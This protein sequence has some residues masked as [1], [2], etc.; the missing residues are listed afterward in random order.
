MTSSLPRVPV[1]DVSTDVRRETA[2]GARMAAEELVSL[3]HRRIAAI[4]GPAHTSTG[5]DREQGFQ[6]ALADAG[7]PLP[8]KRVR[9]GP[10]AYETGRRA[11]HELL[12]G[13]AQ[14]T[15]I[16]CGNDVIAIGALNAAR[17]AGVAVPGEL[18]VIGFDDIAMAAW[19]LFALSTVRQD[20]A[21]MAETAIELLFA[22][23]AKPQRPLQRVTVPTTLVRRRSHGPA[24]PAR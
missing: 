2:A 10:F 15:A 19:P 16:F 22:R 18:A 3:G 21:A 9:R 24:R 12:T 23:V 4:F 6:A 13:T 5:R 14:P 8:A 1:T 11:L 20:L 17:E 7:V